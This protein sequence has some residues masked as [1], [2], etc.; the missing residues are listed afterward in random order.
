MGHENRSSEQKSR[1]PGSV[2]VGIA[3]GFLF[4]MMLGNIAIGLSLGILGGAASDLIESR[5][6]RAEKD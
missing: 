1:E 6:D 2:G 3:L 5:K 4:G